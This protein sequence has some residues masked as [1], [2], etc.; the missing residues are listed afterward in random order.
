MC[1]NDNDYLMMNK[2]KEHLCKVPTDLKYNND[3]IRKRATWHGCQ[4]KKKHF[5]NKINL[6]SLKSTA[7][8]LAFKQKVIIILPRKIILKSV[9]AI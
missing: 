6:T 4:H 8:T 2:I 3:E 9:M 7:K 5:L 1:T